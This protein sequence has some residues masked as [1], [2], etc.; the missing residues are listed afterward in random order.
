MK[1]EEIMNS[2]Y[3]SKSIENPDQVSNQ[4]NTANNLTP[5]AKTEAKSTPIAPESTGI[6]TIKVTYDDSIYNNNN[7]GYGQE[8]YNEYDYYGTANKNTA[9]QP[10]TRKNAKKQKNKNTN[11]NANDKNDY[12]GYDYQYDEGYGNSNY[13]GSNKN[14]YSNY[15]G[16]NNKQ[17][18]KGNINYEY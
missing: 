18:Y 14:Y 8:Y 10:N 9:N 3:N 1:K 4:T 6:E 16:Y 12:Y 17:N 5:T 13:Q 7:Y 2:I 11:T 15:G